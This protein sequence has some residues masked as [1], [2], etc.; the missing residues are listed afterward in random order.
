MTCKN[1]VLP[2]AIHYS[3]RDMPCVR[4][5]CK[6]LLCMYSVIVCVTI[7]L[8]GKKRVRVLGHSSFFTSP[9]NNDFDFQCI[10]FNIH[11]LVFY[12]IRFSA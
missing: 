7:L 9:Q 2:I 8:K 3:I 10:F 6:S 1:Y 12:N 4:N 11:S 5:V